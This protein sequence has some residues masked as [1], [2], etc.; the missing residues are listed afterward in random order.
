MLQIFALTR[1]NWGNF[2][3]PDICL[4][5]LLL[6]INNYCID[7]FIHLWLQNGNIII[8]SYIIL[9]LAGQLIKIEVSHINYVYASL[10]V[11]MVQESAGRLGSIP[12]SGRS[13]GEGH[14]NPLQFSCLENP[15]EPGRPHTKGLHRVG[16]DWVTFA[17]TSAMWFH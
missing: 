8:L 3:L 4:S 7:L 12:G 6:N 17:Y 10:V 14:D 11:Q 5:P 15:M 13:P 2:T 9:S 16:H 1:Q